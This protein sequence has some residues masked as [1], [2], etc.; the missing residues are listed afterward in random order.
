MDS[1]QDL[2]KQRSFVAS[3]P[4][5]SEHLLT[6]DETSK[7]AKSFLRF[8]VGFMALLALIVVRFA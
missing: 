1:I 2:K 8:F 7:Q 4:E 3:A 6:D 5:T